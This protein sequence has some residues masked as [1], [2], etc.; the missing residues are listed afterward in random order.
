MIKMF[1][2]SLKGKEYIQ[3]MDDIDDLDEILSNF[4]TED[5][6]DDGNDSTDEILDMLMEQENEEA[7]PAKKKCKAELE[8]DQMDAKDSD[9]TQGLLITN[10]LSSCSNNLSYM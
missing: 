4:P 7:L 1:I 10:I 2:S 6:N 3:I 8:R 5:D 9:G